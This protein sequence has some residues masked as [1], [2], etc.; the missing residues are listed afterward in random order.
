MHH[1]V[2]VESSSD[3]TRCQSIPVGVSRRPLRS[4]S[5]LHWCLGALPRG[6]S[7]PSAH[8][9]FE[10]FSFAPLAFPPRFPFSLPFSLGFSLALPASSG[11]SAVCPATPFFKPFHLLLP[12]EAELSVST[13]TLNDSASFWTELVPLPPSLDS[14]VKSDVISRSFGW[15][16]SGGG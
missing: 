9:A 6:V 3:K 10:A 16:T 12:I 4:S 14:S 11:C 1:S 13:I 15:S 5:H 7:N 2:L 8:V